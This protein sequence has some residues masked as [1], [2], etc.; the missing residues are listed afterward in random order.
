MTHKSL[1][2]Q[3]KSELYLGFCSRPGSRYEPLPRPKPA[4][5]DEKDADRNKATK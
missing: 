4:T 2:R 1:I 5:N 3:R